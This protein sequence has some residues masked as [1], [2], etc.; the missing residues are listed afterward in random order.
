MIKNAAHPYIE[1]EDI[2]VAIVEFKNGCIGTIN[3]T[4]NVYPSN[5]E[6]TLYLIGE[7]GTIKIGGKSANQIDVYNVYGENDPSILIK[8]NSCIPPNEYG[9]GHTPLFVDFVESIQTGKK[10]FIEIE[11]GIKSLELVLGIYK[12]ALNKQ[13]VQFPIID[14]S[15][16]RIGVNNFEI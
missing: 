15:T 11:D 10:P 5:L 16:E 14:Y 6:E 7:R 3:C 2:G 1:V 9:Y 8:E 13:F 12:S 4:S